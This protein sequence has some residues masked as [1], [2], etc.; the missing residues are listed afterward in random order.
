MRMPT[1]ATSTNL[2]AAELFNAF[3]PVALTFAGIAALTGVISGWINL[4]S[5]SALFGSSYGTVLLIKLALLVFVASAGAYNW[6]SARPSLGGG[7]D[8]THIRR[9]ASIEIALGTA[10]LLVTAILVAVP[11]P[12]P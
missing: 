1:D 3:S 11:T 10:V 7:S 8:T 4:G 9:S 2:H 12:M 6:L 5:L